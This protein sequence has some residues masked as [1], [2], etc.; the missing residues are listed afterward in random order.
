VS[1]GEDWDCIM[2]DA[3]NT[4]IGGVDGC[5]LFFMIFY[6][7][8]SFV[9]LNLFIAIIL[10]AF[11]PNE[12]EEAEGDTGG[13]VFLT[14]IA[15]NLQ[16]KAEAS[17]SVTEDMMAEFVDSWSYFDPMATGYMNYS[18]FEH[19]LQKIRK[20]MGIGAS[21]TRVQ[22]FRILQQCEIIVHDDNKLNFT[23]VLYSLCERIDGCW[24][25]EQSKVYNKINKQLARKFDLFGENQ[26]SLGV[27]LAVTKA[28]RI[29]KAKI[30]AKREQRRKEREAEDKEAE[31]TSNF[32]SYMAQRRDS[33]FGML[34]FGND[35]EPR[36][37]STHT[38]AFV[39]QSDNELEMAEAETK[40]EIESADALLDETEVG[41]VEKQ[42]SIV[43]VDTKE[44]AQETQ[45][46][47][48]PHSAWTVPTAP[49]SK[50]DL[51]NRMQSPRKRRLRKA[52]PNTDTDADADAVLKE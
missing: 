38:F 11:D 41:D 52:D 1:T 26:P 46:E 5:W 3:C 42:K 40:I 13:N 24:L 15:P 28:Q 25:N 27:L 43:S 44:D 6:L 48:Q 45:Q 50:P 8:V 34:K 32:F 30:A 14:G 37:S 35:D 23:E 17:K 12:A 47:I 16:S 22:M 18:S 31:R 20:P 33:G 49:S 19:F 9:T 4:A 29:W 39:E 51:A 7:V 36:E 2:A 21:G 10:Q